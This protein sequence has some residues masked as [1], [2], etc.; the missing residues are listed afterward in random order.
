M[1][2]NKMASSGMNAKSIINADSNLKSAVFP[3]ERMSYS[4]GLK[5]YRG[6]LDKLQ[7]YMAFEK[8]YDEFDRVYAACSVNDKKKEI[9]R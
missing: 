4:T 7:I 3:F 6:V 8:I 5:L 9:K 1:A 2:I